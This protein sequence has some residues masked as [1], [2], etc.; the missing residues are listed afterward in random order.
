[1]ATASIRTPGD[2]LRDAVRHL[3]E[4]AREIENLRA[5]IERASR[6]FDEDEHAGYMRGARRASSIVGAMVAQAETEIRSAQR[7]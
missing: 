4:A 7:R 6:T 1:M 3:H 5:H 2:E